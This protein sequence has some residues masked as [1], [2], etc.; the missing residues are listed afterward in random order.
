LWFVPEKYVRRPEQFVRSGDIL[1]STANSYEL[2]GKVAPVVGVP[3]RATLGAF[4]SL[5]RPGEGV[6][7]KFL[8][9]QLAWGRTQE[10]IRETASTT[11]NISNV[12][13]KKLAAICCGDHFQSSSVRTAP[14]PTLSKSSLPAGLA[15]TRRLALLSC[16]VCEAYGKAA[17]VLR[18]NSRV[19]VEGLRP[20]ARA[21]AR[22]LNPCCL[23]LA[24]VILSSG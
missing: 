2:V 21:M 22:A 1:V 12:S 5:I 18:S 17:S 11:T 10:R 4:I 16:A 8:Y 23:M 14:Q 24:I 9:H 20:S 6:L 15:A 7:P 3:H 19:M 13:T